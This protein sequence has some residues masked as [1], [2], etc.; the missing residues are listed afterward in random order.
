MIRMYDTGNRPYSVEVMNKG[1]STS[2]EDHTLNVSIMC[3]DLSRML[4]STHTF[5]F[6][7]RISGMTLAYY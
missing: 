4:Q 2:P 3:H 7:T 6:Y 1:D 5:Q